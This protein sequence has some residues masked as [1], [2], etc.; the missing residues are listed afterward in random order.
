M[1]DV[2]RGH[3]LFFRGIESACVIA[4][5]SSTTWPSGG[6]DNAAP[7][8]M[9]SYSKLSGNSAML[10]LP[11]AQIILSVFRPYSKERRLLDQNGN[12]DFSTTNGR[13]VQPRQLYFICLPL[14]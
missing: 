6:L 7:S 10:D 1:V 4:R 3:C 14:I 13:R 5:L 11:G 9:T 8:P 12:L 2:A